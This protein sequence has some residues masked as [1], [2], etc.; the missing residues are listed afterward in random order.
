[1][2]AGGNSRVLNWGKTEEKAFKD[3]K[4]ALGMSPAL[5]LPDYSKPFFL[6]VGEKNGF[7]TAVVTQ[8]YQGRMRPCGYY[9]TRLDAVE[10]GSHPCERAMAATAFG[11]DRAQNLISQGGS[12]G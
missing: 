2:C 6:Y 4:Q 5:G 12:H 3:L 8:K 10:R 11:L 9:S 7:A 1:M